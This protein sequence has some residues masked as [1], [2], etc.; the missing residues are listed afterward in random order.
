[1]AKTYEEIAER[2]KAIVDTDLASAKTALTSKNLDAYESAKAKLTKSVEE[3]NGCLRNLAFSGFVATDNPLVTA[4]RQ[5]YITTYRVKE[6]RDKET[7][8]TT[9]VSVI[10]NEKTR[11][12]AEAFCEFAGIDRGWIHD[13]ANLLS[14]LQLRKTDIYTLKPAEL[15]EKSYF[16]MAAVRKKKEGETP[17]SNTKI[18]AMLQKIVDAT[19]YEDNGKGQNAHKCTH[20]DIAFIEDCAHQFDP[21]AKA[22]IKSLKPRGFQTVMVSVLWS[23]LTGEGYTV[24]NMKISEK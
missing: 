19:I 17:D 18:V 1:M 11:I 24:K 12:D 14:L 4:I 15:L 5:F 3:W 10:P 2:A 22:G 21:K 23:M 20:K 13:C 8:K 9:D 16:F 7:G 6:T